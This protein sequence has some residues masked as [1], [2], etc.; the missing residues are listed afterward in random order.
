MDAAGLSR[1]VVDVFA[2]VND[3]PPLTTSARWLPG[4]V[5]KVVLQISNHAVPRNRDHSGLPS[6]VTG[7]EG[8]RSS[9][10]HRTVVPL[11]AEPTMCHRP[12]LLFGGGFGS[13]HVEAGYSTCA[14]S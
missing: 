2:D 3:R 14:G 10:N 7:A 5:G 12:T 8:D 9:Q 1:P 13:S 11:I 6:G 4:R